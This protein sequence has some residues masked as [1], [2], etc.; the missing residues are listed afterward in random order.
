MGHYQDEEEILNKTVL[1]KGKLSTDLAIYSCWG[2]LGFF[3][4]D[5]LL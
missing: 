1:F 5:K 2:F 3:F 4:L